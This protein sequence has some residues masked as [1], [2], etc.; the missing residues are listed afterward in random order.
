MS[1]K[2]SKK[3]Q[4]TISRLKFNDWKSSGCRQSLPNLLPSSIFNNQS[5]AVN[6]VYHFSDI[7]FRNFA[8]KCKHS[9]DS[10][11]D[12]PQLSHLLGPTYMKNLKVKP[13]V[14]DISY[15][16]EVAGSVVTIHSKES[17]ESEDLGGGSM[18][19]SEICRKCEQ[20]LSHLNYFDQISQQDLLL[21]SENSCLETCE[22]LKSPTFAKF[23]FKNRTM[24]L[25][26][27]RTRKNSQF[28]EKL[29][30]SFLKNQTLSRSYW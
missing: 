8:T 11:P 17:S 29:W 7:K 27:Q 10:M 5:A 6:K 19:E 30:D 25:N 26:A 1:D 12:L 14:L 21:S 18:K 4:S 13:Y 3:K 22:L 23:S 9:L 15:S 16:E 28:E 24:K 2:T 20:F